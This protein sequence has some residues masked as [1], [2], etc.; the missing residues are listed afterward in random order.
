LINELERSYQVYLESDL[1]PQVGQVLIPVLQSNGLEVEAQGLSVYLEQG[2]GAT[3][4]PKADLWG[5]SLCT[6]GKKIPSNSQPGDLWFDPIE[7]NLAIL[8]EHLPYQSDD[9]TS[10]IS[11]HPVYV[12]Q[13]RTFLRLVE[14]G[15]KTN[16]YALDTDYLSLVRVETLQSLDFITNIYQDE[17]LAYLGWMGKN[18]CDQGQ[19]KAANEQLNSS[20]MQSILP[21]PLKVWE[22]S[23]FL[24]GVRVA[25][26][27]NTLYRD[28]N[29]DYK[30]IIQ[31][32]EEMEMRA[33][34]MMF[35]EWERSSNVG[36][37]TAVAL[38]TGS[39]QEPEAK[40]CKTFYYEL[41]N[42]AP[43]NE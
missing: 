32:N 3:Y 28:P 31:E 7:L 40:T 38:F 20:Q 36:L 35:E 4:F 19:L 33:G 5:S 2:E 34:Q 26:A 29:L 25:V 23:E 8:V 14:V 24:E 27:L 1:H 10:W 39:R 21:P 30:N 37:V 16:P 41:L 9:V 42:R 43:F 18:P 17:A 22:G 11:I 6:V 13:Y 12:W 15:G